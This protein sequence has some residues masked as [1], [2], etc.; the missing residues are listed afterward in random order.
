MRWRWYHYYFLLAMFD[1]VVIAASL[2]LNHRT[3]ESFSVALAELHQIDEAENW[4]A[5]LRVTVL[6]LNAPGNDVFETRQVSK[7]RRRFNRTHTRFGALMLREREFDIDLSAFR[8]Q[9]EQMVQ[10]EEQIFVILG[11]IS[12]ADATGAGEP[13]R[14]AQATSIMASMDRHQ[15]GAQQSLGIALQALGIERHGLLNAYRVGLELNEAIEKLL[16]GTV[17]LILLGVFWYGRKLQRT[18]EQMIRGQQMAMEEKHARLAAVGEVCSAVAHGIRNPLA[19]ITSSTQL[20]LEFGTADDATKLRIQDALDESRR[21]DER[22]TRLLSFSRTQRPNFERCE[23][24]PII[25]DA[26]QEIRPKLDEG[27][28]RVDTDCDRRPLVIEG[29]RDWLTQAIIEVA[30]NSM[31]HMPSG[32]TLEVR[33]RRDAEQSQFARIDIIDDGPGIPDSVRPHVFDLFFTSKAEG[34]GIG[35][36]SVKRAV[37]MHGGRVS[38]APYNGRGAH[39]EILLPL[40]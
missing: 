5:D 23:L 13:A 7:E 20:A 10:D 18:H 1:V 17:V 14:L 6:Q 32:G 37:E 16:L 2:A 22:I 27:R 9:V 34:N 4:L 28:I 15:V 8:E 39:I 11:E 3:S 35:L 21:L 24:A 36:A 29:D 12:E 30:S 33:C 31:E 40:A 19:A 38:V 25:H 26:L